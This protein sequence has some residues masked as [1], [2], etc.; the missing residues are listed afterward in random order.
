MRKY[1][2]VSTALFTD[3]KSVA[4]DD[5]TF[6]LAIYLLAGPHANLIGCFRN[7]IAYIAHDL[8]KPK[9]KV[10]RNLDLLKKDGWL[11]YCEESSFVWIKKFILHNQFE[12]PNVARAA[13]ATV[14]AV[15]K[16][17]C[18]YDEFLAKTETY[19]HWEWGK[20]GN[21][22]NLNAGLS[23]TIAQPNANSRA[24]VPEPEPEPEPNQNQRKR[25]GARGSPPSS[26]SKRAWHNIM[27]QLHNTA[28]ATTDDPIA[29]TIVKEMGGF[30]EL[31]RTTTRELGFKQHEFVDRYKQLTNE[32]ASK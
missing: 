25:A 9:P 6:R 31:G 10:K 15:P 1:G 14:L 17:L 21:I 4:W 29:G 22:F 24:P 27:A 12:T 2:K 20:A 5:A 23:E 18:F 26:D 11:D 3:P 32:R 13:M 16:Q 7:P 8:A 28:N 19:G 30:A